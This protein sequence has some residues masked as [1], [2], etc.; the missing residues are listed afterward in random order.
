MSLSSALRALL[1]L[2]ATVGIASPA[3]ASVSLT[4]DPH[5]TPTE[6]E[7]ADFEA[8]VRR[9][10]GTGLENL[11]GY[12]GSRLRAVRIN[13]GRRATCV[14]NYSP[15]LDQPLELPAVLMFQPNHHYWGN[16]TP[17]T[18]PRERGIYLYRF[19]AGVLVPGRLGAYGISQPDGGRLRVRPSQVVS[20]NLV[21]S[22][23]ERSTGHESLP[24]T[25]SLIT[26]EGTRIFHCKV[27]G[28]RCDPLTVSQHNQWGLCEGLVKTRDGLG[29]TLRTSATPHDPLPGTGCEASAIIRGAE[30]TETMFRRFVT[31]RQ[32]AATFTSIGNSW[33]IQ[34]SD[35][36]GVYRIE[37]RISGQLIG[38]LD[39]EVQR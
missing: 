11:R 34:D 7:I 3:S 12:C 4:F 39:F 15:S 32:G 13:G 2:A 18:P 36:P 20:W 28:F 33:Q 10:G 27:H 8:A 29:A 31:P 21:L 17:I 1:L 35:P 5:T 19:G 14:V 38:A 26:P 37:V 16:R 30:S 23:D 25:E 22:N 24:Y 9:Y 6:A